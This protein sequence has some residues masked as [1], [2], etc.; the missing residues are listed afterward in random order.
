[1]TAQTDDA[2]WRWAGRAAVLAAAVLAAAG[3]RPFA[4]A[5]NDGSRLAAAESLGE[6]GTLVIDDSIFV[7]VPP[8]EEGRPAPYPPDR[9]D[10]LLL[11]T[12][13]KL[14]VGGHFYSDKSPVP[15][16]LMAGLYR[17]WL[18]LGGPTADE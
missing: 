11:G 8:P 16:V 13:D 5:W 18:A 10:L 7:R 4:G 1:M 9:P 12:R 3:A 17:A 15:N 14:L 2:R 6:R